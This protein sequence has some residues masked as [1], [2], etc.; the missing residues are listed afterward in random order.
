MNAIFWPK[1]IEYAEIG[2]YAVKFNQLIC[3]HSDGN[4]N[5]KIIILKFV[6]SNLY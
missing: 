6:Y 2:W 5:G 4:N 1:G 3:S